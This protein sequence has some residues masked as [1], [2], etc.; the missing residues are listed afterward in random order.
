MS[1]K[2]ETVRKLTDT[3]WL[4]L[5]SVDYEK[6]GKVFDMYFASRRKEGRLDLENPN[7]IINDGSIIVPILKSGKILMEEQYRPITDTYEIEFPAGLSKLEETPRECAERELKEETG[8]ECLAIKCILPP[9]HT[10]TGLTD[11]RTAIYV[12]FVDGDLG[13]TNLDDSEDI[14]HILVDIDSI[15]EFVST[16]NVCQ[17]DSLIALY[18]SANIDNIKKDLE[19]IQNKKLLKLNIRTKNE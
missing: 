1:S 18:V 7:M 13:N 4:N 10:A 16:H 11:E 8:M 12:A 5:Y 2:L 17:R 14:T 6:N 15:P 19:S 9:R 3:K